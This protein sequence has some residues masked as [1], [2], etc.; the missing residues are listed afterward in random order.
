LKKG[1]HRPNG[2]IE[3][4]EVCQ[5]PHAALEVLFQG[6]SR[7]YDPV[8]SATVSSTSSTGCRQSRAD[9][10]LGSLRHADIGRSSAGTAPEVIMAVPAPAR[11]PLRGHAR[12]AI[13]PGRPCHWPVAHRRAG[14]ERTW[15]RTLL[16]CARAGMN[17][18]A[19]ELKSVLLVVLGVGNRPRPAGVVGLQVLDA[20][21]VER[22]PVRQIRTVRITGRG[23]LAPAAPRSCAARRHTGYQEPLRSRR[24]AFPGARLAG[25]QTPSCPG[26][27]LKTR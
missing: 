9:G 20:P 1:H 11:S 3:V 6:P 16:L 14:P 21:V 4:P 22:A 15:P 25:S 8:R 19:P 26:F 18:G 13:I 10:D 12:C 17:E 27:A 24:A 2:G 23:E 7:R 5:A